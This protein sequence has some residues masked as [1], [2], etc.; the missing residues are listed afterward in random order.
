MIKKYKLWLWRR[1]LKQHQG[2]SQETNEFIQRVIIYINK[3]EFKDSDIKE[4]II[5]IGTIP[6]ALMA[7]ETLV[8][9]NKTF[10]QFF[11]IINEHAKR[12]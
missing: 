12:E 3:Q 9:M 4:Q 8:T 11:D 2:F 10:N 1:K 7:L 6:S 5:F